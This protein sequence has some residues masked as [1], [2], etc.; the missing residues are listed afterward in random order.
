MSCHVMSCHVMSVLYGMRACMQAFCVNESS[1]E[2]AGIV[3][4]MNLSSWLHNT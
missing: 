2:L 1:A 3:V 4:Y